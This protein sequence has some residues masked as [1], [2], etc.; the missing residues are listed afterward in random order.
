MRFPLVYQTTE[1][2]LRLFVKYFYFYFFF[3][4]TRFSDFSIDIE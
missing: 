1:I 4:R 3:F 2:L